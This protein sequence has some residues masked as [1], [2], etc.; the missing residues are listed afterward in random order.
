MSLVKDYYKYFRGTSPAIEFAQVIKEAIIYL[1]KK[2]KERYAL[3]RTEATP[4][5]DYSDMPGY[6]FGFRPMELCMTELKTLS[7]SEGKSPKD[8]RFLQYSEWLSGRTLKLSPSAICDLPEPVDTECYATYRRGAH[9]TG[10]PFGNIPLLYNT[11]FGEIYYYPM[12]IQIGK[13][14][15]IRLRPDSRGIGIICAVN[16]ITGQVTAI[17]HQM[18]HPFSRWC[19]PELI[20]SEG[21]NEFWSR[22]I[23]PSGLKIR[24][25]LMAMTEEA[26][27]KLP[28]TFDLPSPDGLPSDFISA[29]GSPLNAGPMSVYGFLELIY[30]LPHVAL[31]QITTELSSVSTLPMDQY[32]KLLKMLG[33]LF[34]SALQT[35]DKSSWFL[36]TILKSIKSAG[37]PVDP[38][39]TSLN[40]WLGINK[41]T[42]KKFLAKPTA[43][44]F[45]FFMLMNQYKPTSYEA[46]EKTY[47]NVKAL[48]PKTCAATSRVESRA[49]RK[50]IRQTVVKDRRGKVLFT[51]EQMPLGMGFYSQFGLKKYISIH[52]YFKWLHQEIKLAI[53]Q[54][55]AAPEDAID[56]IESNLRDYN[57][58]ATEILPSIGYTFPHNL[59]KAHDAMVENYNRI[60]KE[61]RFGAPSSDDEFMAFARCYAKKRCDVYMDTQFLV[62]A[63]ASSLD[64]YE[65]GISLNHCV[66]AYGSDI[67]AAKGAMLIFFLR[68]TKN[69]DEPLVTIQVNKSAGE[70][71]YHFSEIAG[72]GN[73]LPSEEETTFCNKWLVA[74]N[75]AYLDAVAAAKVDTLDFLDEVMTW[76]S[77][78]GL[79]PASLPR[80]QVSESKERNYERLFTVAM[81]CLAARIAEGDDSL[82]VERISHELATFCGKLRLSKLFFNSIVSIFDTEVA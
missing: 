74:F 36:I 15:R 18:L 80:Y 39:I 56:I 55:K 34:Q 67:I 52:Q 2:D 65:E 79:S 4:P 51:S 16:W 19:I 71:E 48:A 20:D 33:N 41:P 45:I 24:D 75:S 78:Y 5:L 6:D 70:K 54:K 59:L 58:M 47:A 62:R 13:A 44:P 68:S 76:L 43:E 49:L 35:W 7:K 61:R 77:T 10:K 63:P 28:P 23:D 66:G 81:E 12:N 32:L 22:F 27:K 31:N 26:V 8:T 38:Q 21:W 37:K 46:F 11:I 64:L 72:R 40:Q 3:G 82:S 1:L 57:R 73:R 17:G 14:G 30:G 9:Y 42:L 29:P 60:Q 25:E 69:P 50:T 53:L